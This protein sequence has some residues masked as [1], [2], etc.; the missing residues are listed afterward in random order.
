MKRSASVRQGHA[1]QQRDSRPSLPCKHMVRRS[2]I[3]ARREAQGRQG[4]RNR[5]TGRVSGERLAPVD[6]R[7]AAV[8]P[9]GLLKHQKVFLSKTLNWNASGEQT[10]AQ[11]RSFQVTLN[12][13]LPSFRVRA[14][15]APGPRHG[16]AP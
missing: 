2:V 1:T 8:G 9:L 16:R 11:P 7:L 14:R 10:R 12:A 3:P 4:R 5:S 13:M 15:V 6:A